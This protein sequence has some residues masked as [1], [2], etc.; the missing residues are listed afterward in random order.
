MSK[1]SQR[2]FLVKVGDIPGYFMTKTGGNISADVS[3]AY[4]GGSP[5]PELIASPPNVENITVSKILDPVRDNDLI[6]ALR[7]QV[8]RYETTITVTPTDRD[9]VAIVDPAVYSP[10]LLIGLKETDVDASSGDPAPWELE[11]AIGTVR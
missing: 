8:G 10:A 5:D 11:F 1:S 7:Q 2:Q 6:K 4:D 3:K 9:Y